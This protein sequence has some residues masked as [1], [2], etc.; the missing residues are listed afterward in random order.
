MNSSPRTPVMNKFTGA[1]LT[2]TLTEKK[3]NKADQ[4]KFATWGN[5]ENTY[6]AEEEAFRIDYILYKGISGSYSVTS[7]GILDLKAQVDGE[8]KSVS[9]HRGIQTVIKVY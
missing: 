3:G 9:D 6:T 7:A 4:D 8:K 2:D 5:Q 1:G